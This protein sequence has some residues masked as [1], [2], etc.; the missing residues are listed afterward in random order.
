MSFTKSLFITLIF[1][2]TACNMTSTTPTPIINQTETPLPI[3]SQ[4]INRKLGRGVNLGNALEAPSEGEW[5]VILQEE[6]IDLIADQGFDSVRI[7]IRWSAH[8][9]LN[10]PYKIDPAFFERVDWAV[11]N[12]LRRNL[13]VVINFH[14]Y[15]EIF[16][17]PA[18][19]EERFLALWSQVAEHYQ[20]SPQELVFEILNEPHDALSP[21]RWNNLLLKTLQVIRVTN[22]DR[23]VIIGPP[24]WNAI[25]S[26][27]RLK[28]PE[29]DQNLIVTVH[30]YLPFEFTH[31]GAEWVDGSNAWLGETWSG[32]SNQRSFVRADL[33]NAYQWG[34]KN[35]RPIYLGEFGAYSKADMDSRASWTEFVAS[36]AE[37]YD[38]SW[39]YWEFCAGFGIYNPEAKTWNQPLVQALLPDS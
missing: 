12:A 19:H 39:A 18:G 16:S 22:P 21:N 14:H 13:A 3:D 8:A 20:D 25:R 27:N 5:G 35:N 34:Q 28:L 17:D 32:T 36:T 31:Q 11:E 2:L 37:E 10:E 9:E 1:S 33:N 38:F 29:E 26:L 24:E 6:Y 30:Y 23:V 4:Q 7:P 15:E